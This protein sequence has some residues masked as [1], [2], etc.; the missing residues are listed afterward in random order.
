MGEV[1]SSLGLG[2]P[3]PSVDPLAGYRPDPIGG[4]TEAI[5]GF[6]SV[7]RGGISESGATT[8]GIDQEPITVTGDGWQPKKPT[9]L[10]AI[11]DAY[12]MSKGMKPAFSVNRDA[13]NVNEAMEGFTND[14]VGAINRM[15]RIR[16]HEQDAYAMHDKYLD[17]RRA[18]ASAGSLAES[19]QAKYLTRIGGLLRSIQKQSDPAAAYA[20]S[21]PLL[22]RLEQRAGDIE[23]L[24]E[25]Y[26]EGAVNNYV[27]MNVDPD[28]QIRMEQLE[29]WRE[30]RKEQTNRRLT[31][32]EK[33][34]DATEGQA[35]VNEQGR[36]N[37]QVASEAG[38]NVRMN[39]QEA[40]R[41]R[42]SKNSP[43]RVVKTPNGYMELSPSGV[44]GKI[45]DQIWRKTAPGQWERIK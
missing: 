9:I 2:G 29:A 3:R 31:E 22:R 16:G 17:N 41:D 18:D 38:K 5:M 35:A 4:M 12:L 36:N 24:G 14:P 32:T 37:R 45:G 42:R 27:G 20:S 11:A 6:P 23:P 44:L 33:H 15:S 19:R 25:T 10:G 8:A 1:L 28:D 43:P 40:G 21:L 13:R 26:D 34:N 39:I 7:S 30:V